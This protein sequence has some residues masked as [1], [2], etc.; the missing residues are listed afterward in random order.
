MK[1]TCPKG[2]FELT[3]LDYEYG[4]SP[5]FLERNW[6][7]VGLKTRVSEREYQ[8]MAP[9]LSTWEIE[10]LRDWLHSVAKN[11]PLSPK[12]TF[13]EPALTFRASTIGQHEFCFQIQ[14][15]QNDQPGQ[16]TQPPYSLTI[17]TDSQQLQMAI[18]DLDIQLNRFPVRN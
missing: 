8:R 13:V 18:H 5:H 11:G 16:T 12:L 9:L 7:L 3:I 2:E 14:L 1:L 6:L 10:L 17:N 15:A 4:D